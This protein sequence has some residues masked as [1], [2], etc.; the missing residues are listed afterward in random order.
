VIATLIWLLGRQR[1]VTIR[2]AAGVLSCIMLVALAT[3]WRYQPFD[4][5][6]FG[7]YVR[8]FEQVP[9]GAVGEFPLNPAGIWTMR[10][11]KK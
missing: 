11:V 1:P 2:L 8:A 9:S 6:Q 10:L 3:H 7:G 5:S 4:N